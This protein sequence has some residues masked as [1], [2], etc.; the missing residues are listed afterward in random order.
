VNQTVIK[1]GM[2]A[3]ASY[4]TPSGLFKFVSDIT[5]DIPFFRDMVICGFLNSRVDFTLIDRLAKRW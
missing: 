4:I 2:E 1:C 5:T 3:T